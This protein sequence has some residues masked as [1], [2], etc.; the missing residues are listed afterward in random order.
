MFKADIHHWDGWV[1]LFDDRREGAGKLLNRL[2]TC[3][4]VMKIW[5]LNV[6]L[7]WEHVPTHPQWFFLSKVF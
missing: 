6:R 4:A 3:H 5:L 7:I 2:V 1:F